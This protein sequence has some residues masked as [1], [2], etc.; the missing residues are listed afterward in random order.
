MERGAWALPAVDTYRTAGPA[1]L[2]SLASH[3]LPSLLS[4]IS[5]I[6]SNMTSRRIVGDEKTILDRD[7]PQEKS[8]TSPAVPRYACSLKL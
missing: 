6:T 5:H 4:S 1:S 8:D 2:N 7:D 3:S